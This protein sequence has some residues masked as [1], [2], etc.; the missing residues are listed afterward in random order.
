MLPKCSKTAGI[1]RMSSQNNGYTVWSSENN[2]Y[3]MGY[4]CGMNPT[5]R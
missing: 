1:T 5:S 2:V 4:C 3:V